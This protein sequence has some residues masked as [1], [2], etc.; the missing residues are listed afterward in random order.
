MTYS[1][2]ISKLRVEL[3]DFIRLQRDRWDGDG[4]TT[5]FPLAHVAVKDASY[6]VKVGGAVK[7]EATDYTIDKDTGLITF[8]IAPAAGSDNVECTYR[9][10]N[11]RDEDYVEMIN[12][13]IDYF[14]WKFW[15]MDTDETTLTTVK[16]QYE[17]DCSGITGILYV[18][19]SWYKASSG[20]TVWQAVSGLTNCKYYVGLTKLY[21]NP[22]FSST[23]L[24]MKLL[25]LKSITKGSTSSATL[26]I[27]N[28][29]I[30]PYK[31]YIYARYYERLIPEK[32]NET[33]A[34]TTLPSFTPAQ[35]VFNISQMYYNK[36][37]DVAKKLAPRMPSMS[38]KQ[39]QDGIAM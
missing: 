21:V 32:I 19:N 20:S 5:I 17:Y 11:V 37:D 31:F 14:Q 8:T 28:K 23:G 26:A 18:L 38:I 36:A 7:V 35:A 27:P 39:I 6:V 34:V 22:T 10:V 25:Y 16:D 9:S 30:L 3:K 15:E 24:T 2:F 13:G 29:W 12:D 4:S 33:A 1:Q